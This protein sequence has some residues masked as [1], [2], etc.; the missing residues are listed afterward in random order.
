MLVAL[1]RKK[2]ACLLS[3]FVRGAR[4]MGWRWR[5]PAAAHARCKY[6][7]GT[8]QYLGSGH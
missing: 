4:G 6:A 2:I 7:V 5:L 3:S 1:L 8:V